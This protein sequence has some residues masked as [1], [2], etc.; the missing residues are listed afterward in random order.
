M[1]WEDPLEK[2]KATH[3]S[4]LAWRIPWTVA[5]QAPLSMGFS[6]QEYWSRLP[7]PSPGDLPDPGIKPR[8]PTLQTD[9]LSSEPLGNPRQHIKKQRHYFVHKCNKVDLGSIPGSGISPGEGNGNPLQY[10]CLENPMDGRAWWCLQCGRPG[11]D[12]WVRNIPWRRKWQPT[13]VL[14]PGESNGQRTL[15]GY[16]PW[17]SKS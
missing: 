2:G 9:S 4:I 10:S 14:L 17:G 6:R 15:A 3:F 7:F 12:P 8:S 13:L 1:G 16:S 5:H 11:F